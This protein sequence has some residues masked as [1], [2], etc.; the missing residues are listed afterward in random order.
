MVWEIR[1]YGDKEVFQQEQA[2]GDEPHKL[3]ILELIYEHIENV[4]RPS[5]D[6]GRSEFNAMPYD[7]RGEHKG[8]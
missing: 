1:R 3:Q 6:H 5:Q 8:A 7:E 4:L 2:E